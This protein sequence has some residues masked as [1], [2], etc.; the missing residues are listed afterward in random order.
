MAGAEAAG[1]GAPGSVLGDAG[2]PRRRCVA[3]V[4]AGMVE[5]MAALVDAAADDG[6]AKAGGGVPSRGDGVAA[7]AAAGSGAG[8]AAT[9]GVD[10]VEDP[11]SERTRSMP[12]ARTPTHALAPAATTRRTHI[13]PRRFGRPA[14]CSISSA[15][16]PNVSFDSSSGGTGDGGGPAFPTRFAGGAA[17]VLIAGTSG[18]ADER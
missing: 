4:G 9:A 8:G 2:A 16:D 10:R 1:T 7:G 13:Q 11:R 18:F 5:E 3:G 15:A 6:G 12:P 17:S 14:G